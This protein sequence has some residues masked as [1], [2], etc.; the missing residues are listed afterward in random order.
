VNSEMNTSAN[1]WMLHPF[2]C[3]CMKCTTWRTTHGMGCRCG[4]KSCWERQVL[5]ED[6]EIEELL[7]TSS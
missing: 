1:A 4:L 7:P 6:S 3:S 2:G 5:L